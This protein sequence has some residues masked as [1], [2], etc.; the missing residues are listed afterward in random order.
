MNETDLRGAR[1]ENI[2]RVRALVLDLD[3]GS[4]DQV[5]SCRLRPHLVVETSPGRHHVYWELNDAL[6][7]DEFEDTIRGIAVAFDGD[8]AVALLTHRARLPGFFHNKREPFLVR[9]VAR[10]AHLPFST[11]EIQNQ[12][13]PQNKPHKASGSRPILPAGAPLDAAEEFLTRCHSVAGIA[14]LHHYRGAFYRWTGTHY[15]ETPQESIERQLYV[16][17][18]AA[19]VQT[20]DGVAPFNPT[21]NKIDQIVHALR[22]GTLIEQDREVPFWLNE[23]ERSAENLVACANGIL[24]IE[25]R[26]LIASDPRFF[27]TGALPLDYDPAASKPERWLRF[28]EEIWPEDEEAEYCLQEIFGYLLT[29]D[30]RQHK[31]FL[32]WGPK[33]GGKGTIIYVLVE[34]LGRGNVVYQTL[35]S[36]GGEFG[37][38]P[39]IDKK[40]CCVTDARLDKATN[41]AALAETMLSI[42]GGDPQTINRKLQSFWNGYLKVRFLITTNDL[43]S[44]GDASGT[45]PSRF[46]LLRMTE[47]FL[48]RE[49]L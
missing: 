33:R 19:L 31:I 28:L 10:K 46:I 5:D 42:S 17:L 12:F 1:R 41:T 13:P 7:L 4:L 30:T 26:E 8:P 18:K 29:D 36:M 37:R 14:L 15:S 24:N 25:T 6:P 20:K 49:V 9:I 38:W 45:L 48:G 43:L 22:R 16:F 40:L 34:L 2:K 27:C 21:K 47:S 11:D 44:I 3:K 23:P 35:K 39:L 32:I